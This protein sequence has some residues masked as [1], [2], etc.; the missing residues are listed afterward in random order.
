MP[1]H[2]LIHTHL[3]IYTHKQTPTRAV[4]TIPLHT[5]AQTPPPPL[6]PPPPPP[7]LRLIPRST[8]LSLDKMEGVSGYDAFV[9]GVWHYP[10]YYPYHYY[11]YHHYHPYHHH[12]YPLLLRPIPRSTILSLDKMEGVSGYDAFVSGV[13]HFI[14]MFFASAAIGV[15]FG[16][17]SALI[18][19]TCGTGNHVIVILTLTPVRSAN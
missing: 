13:W 1:T 15:V 8:I 16:L 4:S 9:S 5:P 11:Y 19:F 17:V 14:M 10:H 18:S 2:S 12:P 3:S 6:P 7:L